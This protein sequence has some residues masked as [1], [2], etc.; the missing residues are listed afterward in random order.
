MVLARTVEIS[1]SPGLGGC[2]QALQTRATMV[3]MTLR[4]TLTKVADFGAFHRKFK[5]GRLALE[6]LGSPKDYLL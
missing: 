2:L 1:E 6:R 5:E 4:D 3:I